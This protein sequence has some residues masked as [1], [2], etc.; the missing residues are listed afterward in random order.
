MDGAANFI[1]ANIKAGV[2]IYFI[3]I[4]ASGL[5]S[6]IKEIP[7]NMVLES[8]IPH[9]MYSISA[10]LFFQFN[11]FLITMIARIG[12]DANLSAAKNTAAIILAPE[13]TEGRISKVQGLLIESRG[14][15]ALIGEICHIE[16][17]WDVGVIQ[18]EV[19]GLRD[20][21]IQLIAYGKTACIGIGDRVIAS[22]RRL[23]V[24]V[25][26]KLLGRVLDAFGNLVDGKENIESSLRYPAMADP[27]DPL[28]R[29]RI[30]KKISTGIRA[31][32]GLLTA[33]CGQRLGILGGSGAGKSTLLG[34]IARNNSA[35]VNVVVL[36]GGRSREIND[37]IEKYLGIEGLARSVLIVTPSN[38]PSIER[39][40][41]AYTATAVA[42]YFRDQGKDVMLLFDSVTHFARAQWDI[43]LAAGKSLATG[44]Y[45]PSVFVSISRLMERCGISEKGTITGFYTILVDGDDMD[46]QV[47]DT[48]RGSLDGYIILSQDLARKSH[49]PAIDVLS[50]NSRLAST[51]CGAETKKAVKALKQ[52]KAFYTD[53]EDLINVGA[54]REGSDLRMDMA[55]SKR[56]AIEKFLVQKVDEESSMTDTLRAMGEITGICIPD[57]EL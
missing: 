21:I 14:P 10:G 11:M 46:E 32:D 28:Q 3:T 15:Q 31:I 43:S 47:S 24:M 19:V 55:I 53:A 49:Y 1:S 51:V 42:E 56:D 27:P 4:V 7:L 12:I 39:L 8:I 48:V 30:T 52:L 6:F 33:G 37:F 36:V 9:L 44:C 20:E 38:A 29:P 41:G 16:T 45:S 5:I 35:D 25:S 13:N 26:P 23:E 54:Y 22:G 57:D 18:A 2:W 50:S 34:M 17:S 40:R